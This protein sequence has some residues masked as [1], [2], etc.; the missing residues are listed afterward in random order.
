MST[1]SRRHCPNGERYGGN[2]YPDDHP[3]ASDIT[4]ERNGNHE[5][6]RLRSGKADMIRLKPNSRIDN[7]LCLWRS[8]PRSEVPYHSYTYRLDMIKDSA[9]TKEILSKR[10]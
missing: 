3:I 7:N 2:G 4:V 6:F 10:F 8:A 5:Y 1:P 9:E